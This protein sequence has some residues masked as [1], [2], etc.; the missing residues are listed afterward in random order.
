M[1]YCLTPEKSDRFSDLLIVDC[2][3]KYEYE[4]NSTFNTLCLLIICIDGHIKNAINISSPLVLE[5]IF[6][7]HP[8]L[9]L[10]PD[11]INDIKTDLD[12]VLDQLTRLRDQFSEN[13][14][15]KTSFSSAPLIVFHCEFSIERGP[16]MFNYMR[17]LDRELN[18]RNYPL[19]N[20][21]EIYI[22]ADGYSQFVKEH[23]VSVK[24]L[25]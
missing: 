9:L 15:S 24:I 14:S 3:F 4:S 7:S 17:R 21:P 23:G 18:E 19:L 5:Q 16:R 12:N 2:R 22:L 1:D 13:Y 6:F 10:K 25:S 20:Y 11:Y 8:D